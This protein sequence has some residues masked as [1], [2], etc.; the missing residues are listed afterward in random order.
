MTPGGGIVARDWGLAALYNTIH[1]HGQTSS[2]QWP[3][4]GTLAI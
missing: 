3:S 1:R 2:Q 4:I